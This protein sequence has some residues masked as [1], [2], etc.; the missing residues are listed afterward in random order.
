MVPGQKLG[1]D[2]VTVK[3]KRE[4]P[5]F[6]TGVYIK[7]VKGATVV[8]EVDPKGPFANTFQKGDKLVFINGRRLV[9]DD[10]AL[11]YLNSLS[12]H[13]VLRVERP[14][15]REN[16]VPPPERM[17]LEPDTTLT[18]TINKADI[19]SQVLT[20]CPSQRCLVWP[21][22]ASSARPTLGPSQARGATPAVP[23]MQVG[24]RFSAGKKKEDV[25]V[26]DIALDSL[27]CLPH[28][29][30][31]PRI[32]R[33]SQS[34]CARCLARPC[35]V[36]GGRPSAQGG[37][38]PFYCW[39][40]MHVQ[41]TGN[42]PN[43][44]ERHLHAICAR[45]LP[46]AGITADIASLA[47]VVLQATKLLKNAEGDVTLVFLPTHSGVFGKRR[48]SLIQDAPTPD[49][50]AARPA[51]EGAPVVDGEADEAAAAAAMADAAAAK[52]AEEVAAAEAAVRE[53]EEVAAA[54]KAAAKAA[55]EVA[56]AAEADS[57]AV[58]AAVGKA[59][60]EKA[61]LEVAA[62]KDA[63]DI[64]A[65]KEAAKQ[66]AELKAALE[67]AAAKDAEEKAAAERAAA[68]QAV[69]AQIRA[70]RE[71]ASKAEAAQAQ[72]AQT[73]FLSGYA[74]FW[75]AFASVLYS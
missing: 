57:A 1:S 50:E 59:A 26:A 5:S 25:I 64:G 66:A 70:A 23:V 30:N 4:S 68:L 15:K 46:T 37:S 42:G 13:A 74:T 39:Q 69:T 43:I 27:V 63:D 19:F 55:A 51:A 67:V 65:L 71:R 73:G 9:D 28:Q 2:L 35:P 49:A 7:N 41:N 48:S 53:A 32:S 72:Q 11:P 22:A 40:E 45:H 16:K 8:T 14:R 61:A 18:L 24:L 10:G 20:T 52:E 36:T 31:R 33:W 75:G 56:A 47:P 3:L 6:R 44:A 17:I 60:A 29:T 34:T 54:A 38:D 21:S 12:G 62:K 58:K